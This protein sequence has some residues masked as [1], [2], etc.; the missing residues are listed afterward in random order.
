LNPGES[1][2]GTLTAVNPNTFDIYIKPEKEILAGGAEGSI[3]LT[4]EEQNQFGF[5][6]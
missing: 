1:Y 6:S 5:L 4:G 3:E 2:N